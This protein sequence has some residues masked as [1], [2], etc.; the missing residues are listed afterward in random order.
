MSKLYK[1]TLTS[2]F[3]SWGSC[4]GTGWEWQVSEREY[5]YDP[6]EYG[7]KDWRVVIKTVAARCR[8]EAEALERARAWI[9]AREGE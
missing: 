5:T 6:K 8:S 9:K 7:A 1:I 3:V 2:D 4:D